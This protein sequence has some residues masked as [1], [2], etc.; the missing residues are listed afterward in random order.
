MDDTKKCSGCSE[1]M[2]HKHPHCKKCGWAMGGMDS[3]S[4]RACKCGHY[5][6]PLPNKP[7][8]VAELSEYRPEVGGWVR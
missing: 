4:G 8:T 5:S 3:W 2:P 7:A 6:P 1:P